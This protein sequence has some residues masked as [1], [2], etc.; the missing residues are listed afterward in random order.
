MRNQ[1]LLKVN[2]KQKEK[3]MLGVPVIRTTTPPASP[4]S[5]VFSMAQGLQAGKT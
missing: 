3:K 1:V 4:L 5:T 2:W